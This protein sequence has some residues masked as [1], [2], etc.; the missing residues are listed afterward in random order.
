MLLAP[1]LVTVF[2]PGFEGQRRELMIAI[3]RI[4]FPMTGVLVLSAWALGILNSHR[5]F[6]IPYFA[7]VLWNVAIIGALIGFRGRGSRD[8][9]LMA[10]A[11]GALAGGFLQFGIQ[12][13]WVL[14]CDR[15][16]AYQHRAP[17]ARVQGRRS[18][19]RP[20]H[21]GPRRRAGEHVCRHGSRQPA[22]HWRPRPHCVTR[23][24]SMSFPSACSA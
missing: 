10:A 1:V 11:W 16:I 3:V 18:Q 8:D 9:L 22:R 6:F 15:E 21:P 5:M 4:I 17:R 2:T 14:R 24:H 7:P 13:P 20:R 12:L 19:R 23:R